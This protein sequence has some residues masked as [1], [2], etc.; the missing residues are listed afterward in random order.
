MEM[1]HPHVITILDS[2]CEMA[3]NSMKAKSPEELGSW[4]KAVT[5]SDGC[6]LIRGFHSQC[7]TFVIVDFISGG[8]LY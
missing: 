1:A 3:K 5:S 7:S 2:M 8:I 6:W 4:S